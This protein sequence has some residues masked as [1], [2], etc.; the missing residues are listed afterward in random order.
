[1]D[2]AIQFE[3]AECLAEAAIALDDRPAALR[4]AWECSG[5]YD[6]CGTLEYLREQLRRLEGATVAVL[7]SQSELS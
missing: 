7:A 3:L 6:S 2:V 1:V 4:K 5:R